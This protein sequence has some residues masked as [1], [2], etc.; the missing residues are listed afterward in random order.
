MLAGTVLLT[1]ALAAATPSKP[2]IDA[3]PIRAVKIILV[4]DSTMAP[5]SGW[6][7]M[8]C[9]EH[10]K[11]SVACLNLGRGCRRVLD[12]VVQDGRRE[13]LDVADAAFSRESARHLDG[14]VDVGARRRA[15]PPLVPVP[16]RREL[17][18]IQQEDRFGFLV[19]RRA[20]AGWAS[21]WCTRA[22]MA[23]VAPT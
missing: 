22:A 2:R 19:H 12:G 16:V 8:F 1:I 21:A 15:L 20:A 3:P 13:H 10:V 17:Q 4:G 23:R 6:A 14:M 11:S 18:R 9:A 5:G 7:S